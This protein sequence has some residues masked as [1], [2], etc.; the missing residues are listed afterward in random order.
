MPSLFDKHGILLIVQIA[1]KHDPELDRQVQEWIE[2]V[3]G[4]NF[5][6]GSYEDAELFQSIDLFE[7]R[8]IPQAAQ[9][10]FTFARHV[11]HHSIEV[12]IYLL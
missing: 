5:S 9:C 11:S 12:V 2:A 7:K 8:N 3:I 10:L 1:V 4:E 6:D